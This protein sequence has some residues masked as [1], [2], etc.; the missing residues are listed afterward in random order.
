[1]MILTNVVFNVILSTV[2]KQITIIH[3]FTNLNDIKKMIQKFTINQ[4]QKTFVLIYVCVMYIYKYTK[5]PIFR[6]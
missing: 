3:F 2:F 1:M 5:T 4:F 6:K